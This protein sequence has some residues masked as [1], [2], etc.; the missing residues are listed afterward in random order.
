MELAQENDIKI[1]EQADHDLRETYIKDSWHKVLAGSISKK[2][3]SQEA[4]TRLT[5]T[6]VETTFL[7]DREVENLQSKYIRQKVTKDEVELLTDILRAIQKRA[8]ILISSE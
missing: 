4:L 2:N 6:M 1:L 3:I 8:D 7:I 5:R